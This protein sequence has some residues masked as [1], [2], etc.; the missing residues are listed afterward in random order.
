MSILRHIKVVFFQL[1]KAPILTVLLLTVA[2]ALAG[3][4]LAR[5]HDLTIVEVANSVAAVVLAALFLKTG[6][7]FFAYR[8]LNDEPFNGSFLLAAFLITPLLILALWLGAAVAGPRID[9]FPREELPILLL[10]L[11][12]LVALFLFAAFRMSHWFFGLFRQ[13]RSTARST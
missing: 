10:G 12:G 6:F 5:R 9:D 8:I 4:D 2:G 11:Y 3:I 7:M 13:K 1:S